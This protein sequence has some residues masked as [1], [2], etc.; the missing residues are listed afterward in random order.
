M[1]TELANPAKTKQTKKMVSKKR[2]NIGKKKWICFMNTLK[3]DAK[4]FTV[5][6]FHKIAMDVKKGYQESECAFSYKFSI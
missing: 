3:Y 4:D 1:L 5:E 2:K 6:D